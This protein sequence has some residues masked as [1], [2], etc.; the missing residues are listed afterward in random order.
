[1]LPTQDWTSAAP[2]WEEL[3]LASTAAYF[4]VGMW[5]FQSTE[6][7]LSVLTPLDRIRQLPIFDLCFKVQ[8]M[9]KRWIKARESEL[10]THQEPSQC[11]LVGAGWDCSNGAPLG[12]PASSFAYFVICHSS[13]W[14]IKVEENWYQQSYSCMDEPKKNFALNLWK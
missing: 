9:L 4:M 2:S 11:P 5:C 8:W 6:G 3:E 10:V 7:F 13:I 12:H 14:V 1:M